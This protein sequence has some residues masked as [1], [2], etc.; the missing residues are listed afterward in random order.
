M[1]YFIPV[2]IYVKDVPG[3]VLTLFGV[4]YP[5]FIYCL[6]KVRACERVALEYKRF[7]MHKDTYK[8]YIAYV[9]VV[10]ENKVTKQVNGGPAGR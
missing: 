7:V 1:G 6:S 9:D 8:V 5:C 3:R 10:L 4:L 2:L